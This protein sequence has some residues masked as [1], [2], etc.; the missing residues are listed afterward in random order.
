M[1]AV[2]RLSK[3]LETLSC[4]V[5]A[6]ERRGQALRFRSSLCP[7][8]RV[9]QE[10]HTSLHTLDSLV[11]SH[12]FDVIS[13]SRGNRQVFANFSSFRIGLYPPFH[14]FIFIKILTHLHKTFENFKKSKAGQ[15]VCGCVTLRASP[16]QLYDCCTLQSRR[17]TVL[18]A[19]SA[20]H[21]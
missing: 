3:L 14:L 11:K 21:T 13:G 8:T 12:F 15:G 1:Q 18:P 7:R 5:Y 20:A 17:G 10:L 4:G 9:A 2:P 6:M 16:V 19:F